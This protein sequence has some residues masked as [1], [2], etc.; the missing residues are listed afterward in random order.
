MFDGPYANLGL[1][2]SRRARD[3]GH[4]RS[5][6]AVGAASR[7]GR[8]RYALDSDRAAA[9]LETWA[10]FDL[11]FVETPLWRDDLDGYAALAA[12]P[13]DRRGRVAATRFEFVEL[14]DRGGVAVAQPDVGR[15]GGLT[16]ARR[17]R[18]AGER[19]REIVPHLWKTG[20]S[21][22]AAAHLAAVT[23][24]CA[25]SSSCPARS[26]AGLRRELTARS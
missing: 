5:A 10:P 24:H 19:G 18:A 6:P 20:I 21:I 22:A 13:P 4:R 17:R 9:V 1:H 2:A 12:Q 3:R 23:P 11:Y 14:L 7:S 8:R 16:A 15:V 26:R 25:T